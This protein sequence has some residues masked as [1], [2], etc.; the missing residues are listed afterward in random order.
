MSGPTDVFDV[1]DAIDIQLANPPEAP[2]EVLKT[3]CQHLHT[4]SDC[5]ITECLDCGEQIKASIDAES[6]MFTSIDN[7]SMGDGNRCWAPKK[8][9]KG[10]REDVKG[11]G[12]PDPVVNVAEDIFKTVT[13]GNIF[14]VDKRKAIIV[15]CLLEAYKIL[16]QEVSL[17]FL[18]K[19]IPVPNITVGTKIVET[20]IKRYDVDR[21]RSTYTSP[22]DSIKDI[23][24][25]WDSDPSVIE[26]VIQLFKKV[27]DRSSL[28]NRSRAKSVAA[29]VVYYYALAT[30]RKSI[31]LK[32][33]ASRVELSDSTIQK[34]AKEISAVLQT[35]EILAY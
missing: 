26:E 23:M 13:G 12:F 15:A 22:E 16:N 4:Q 8:K 28:L 7:R 11:L 6:K 17:D 31:T 20:K 5:G 29:A 10:I 33:F 14:R 25:K 18:L 19:R 9:V 2:P 32:D 3:T 27:E 24:T 34:L 1:F 21:S 30:K 35:K